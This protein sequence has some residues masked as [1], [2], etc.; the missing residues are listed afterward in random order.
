MARLPLLLLLAKNSNTPTWNPSARRSNGVLPRP[1]T[2]LV[3]PQ[4]YDV[5]IGYG[6]P[7]AHL[8]AGINTTRLENLRERTTQQHKMLRFSLNYCS[9]KGKRGEFNPDAVFLA[10]LGVSQVVELAKN[11]K[12][13]AFMNS[14]LRKACPVETTILMTLMYTIEILNFFCAI[15]ITSNS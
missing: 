6:G 1:V 10:A 4:S 7:L 15:R 12:N 3:L 11:R 2:N 13:I 9:F 8:E 5:L 14:I